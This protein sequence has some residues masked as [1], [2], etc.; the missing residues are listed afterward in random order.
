VGPDLTWYPTLALSSLELEVPRVVEVAEIQVLVVSTGS[1]EVRAVHNECSHHHAPLDTS[2]V[3]RGVVTCRF[4]GWRFR[5]SDG[6]CLFGGANIRAFPVEV[7]DG[8]VWIGVG[9]VLTLLGG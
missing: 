7:R 2:P 1:R 6:V 3:D 4:H 5:L 9:P 8:L